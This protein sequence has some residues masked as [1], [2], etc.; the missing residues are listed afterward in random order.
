MKNGILQCVAVLAALLFC[1]PAFAA[2]L[3]LK[4]SFK[5]DVQPVIHDYC[6]NCHEPGGKGYEKSGLDMRTYQ[7]LMKGTR[8]G[9][10]IKPGDSFTSILIQV[11]EGRVH[12]SIK[13][14]YG[15]SGGLARD[16]V[17]LLKKWVDQGALDN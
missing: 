7:S 2:P 13:M 6:L 9:A 10:V 17:E 15:M 11:V 4:T 8:F 1:A 5:R 16:K 14:P 12:A 3:Q